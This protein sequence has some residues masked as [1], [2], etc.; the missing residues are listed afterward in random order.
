[1]R[2]L[3]ALVGLW[4]M[5]MGIGLWVLLSYTPDAIVIPDET[6]LQRGGAAGLLVAVCGLYFYTRDEPAPPAR[7]V[8]ERSRTKTIS[9]DGATFDDR[10]DTVLS[11][12]TADKEELTADLRA[13]VINLL[14]YTNGYDEQTARE[15]LADGSWTDDP[16]A[17]ALFANRRELP[18]RQRL[19]EWLFPQQTYRERVEAVTAEL[20]R[21]SRTEL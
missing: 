19:D 17:A 10:L 6:L 11:D 21:Y 4:L 1:M 16:L 14:C 15:T 12:S 7:L 2:R 8:S 18:L 3:L 20:E 13:E 5:T 9:G